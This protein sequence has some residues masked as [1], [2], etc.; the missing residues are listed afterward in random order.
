MPNIPN[1][2]TI[3]DLGVVVGFCTTF[4]SKELI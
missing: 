1:C 3:M 4:S 2:K